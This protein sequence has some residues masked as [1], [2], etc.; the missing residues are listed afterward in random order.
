MLMSI[1]S[2]LVNFFDQTANEHN[3]RCIFNTLASILEMGDLEKKKIMI[4]AG[5]LRTPGEDNVKY[6]PDKQLGNRFLTFLK[7]QS[8]EDLN[9]ENN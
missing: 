7:Q 8:K 2:F 1:T 4:N 6:E 5:F 3:R 9:E